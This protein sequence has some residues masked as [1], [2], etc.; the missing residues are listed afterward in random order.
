MVFTK[1]NKQSFDSLIR[2]D[3]VRF[4]KLL[5]IT[6]YALIAFYITLFIANIVEHQNLIPQIFKVYDYENAP[7]SILVK[8]VFIDMIFLVI[9]MYYLK[10]FLNCIPFIFSGLSKNYKPSFK[11]EIA[12]GI[13]LGSG[14]VL[15][16]R[17]NLRD[18]IKVIEDRA[19]NL[20]DQLMGDE[21]ICYNYQTNDNNEI[22][23]DE[24]NEDEE[25]DEEEDEEE[26]R[27]LNSYA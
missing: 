3:S 20:Y 21:K 25:D 15:F 10:K 13:S 27:L 18:K 12:T 24:R 19:N 16:P 22:I 9:Y 17:A 14:V 5:E 11:K 4:F 6:Y 26:D 2:L 1:H 23:A 8:D 7:T